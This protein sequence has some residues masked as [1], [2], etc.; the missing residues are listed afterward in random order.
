MGSHSSTVRQ[1]CPNV[2]CRLYGRT[3]R[4]NIKKNGVFKLKR[5]R[6]QRYRCSACGKSFC[7]TTATPY[8]RIQYSRN[9]FDE[10]CYLSVDGLNKSAI[11]RVKKLSWNTVA[12]WLE[13][14]S[15]AAGQFNE[16]KLHGYPLQEIQADEIRTF[17]DRRKS[18][19]WL[20]TLLEVWSRLWPS[21]VVGRRS[22]RNIRK[23]FRNTLSRAELTAPPLITT[24][25]FEPYSWVIRRLLGPACVYGQ[26]I[27]KRRK[28]RI[29]VVDR[30]LLMGTD[31]LLKD[32]LQDSEDSETLN[33]SFIERHNLTL[34]RSCPYLQRRT[35][36]HARRVDR[37]QENLELLQCHYNFIR[38][39]MALKFGRLFKTPAM[40][41]GLT[42][43]PLTFRD[44]FLARALIVLLVF[45]QS[46]TLGSDQRRAA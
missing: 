40:Q 37:L 31:Q 36:A 16:R 44:I 39:H 15:V 6:R 28:N 20:I 24:D 29:T 21:Y 1:T 43:R 33:T 4:G 46:S 3:K 13:K 23:L 26:V 10:V 19:I 11:A 17:V 5:G 22:Y 30:K 32:A 12:R 42:S 9:T 45:S 35:N 38:P 14:A 18:P 2:E 41:A 27:K 8:H 25:G 7:S 34:R